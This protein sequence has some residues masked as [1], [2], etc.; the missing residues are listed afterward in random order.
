MPTL[1]DDRLVFHFPHLEPDADLSI[2]FNRTLRAPETDKSYSVP[3]GL[4]RFPVRHAEDF[5]GALSPETGIRGGVILPMWQGEAMWLE[6]ESE[7]PD[8]W[9][10]FPVAIK[11]AAGKVNAVSGEQW[12]LGLQKRPQDYIVAPEQSSLNGFATQRGTV[13]QFVA[14]HLGEDYTVEEQLTGKAEWGGLQIM[15][16]PLTP[17]AYERY[18]A[19][20]IEIRDCYQS[21]ELELRFAC[22]EMGIAAGGRIKQKICRDPFRKG[23]WDID[24]AQRVYV[25]LIDASKWAAITG[26]QPPSPPPTAKDYVKAG[27]PWFDHYGADQPSV[28]GSG[29][30]A[31]VASLGTLFK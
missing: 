26:E 7:G 10:D 30:L 12:K 11:I 28:N 9:L 31:R 17:K 8:H 2:S 23:S 15:V 14:T 29:I 21:E 24:A 25:S 1:E 6:F 16:A 5:V 27:L 13:R 4:G 22:I 3:I 20:R 18:S 19:E